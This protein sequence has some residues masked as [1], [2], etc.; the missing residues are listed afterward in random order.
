MAEGWARLSNEAKNQPLNVLSQVGPVRD[1]SFLEWTTR[2]KLQFNRLFQMVWSHHHPGHVNVCKRR[3]STI[4]VSRL[5]SPQFRTAV[6]QNTR[7]Q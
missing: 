2:E 6:I 7:I 4:W 1:S 3:T 5:V